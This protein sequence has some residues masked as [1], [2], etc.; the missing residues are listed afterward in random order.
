MT[1]ISD[2]LLSLKDDTYAAFTQKLAPNVPAERIL[3]VRMPALR[4]LARELKNSPEA[5]AFLKTLPH[6][7][8]DEDNLHALLINEIRDPS[9]AMTALDAFLP[10]V[11]NWATCDTLN[12]VCFKHNHAEMY[13]KIVEYVRSEHTYTMRF[14]VCAL[15]RHYLADDFDPS[16]PELLAGIISD[17]YYVNMAIAWYFATAVAQQPAAAIPYLASTRLPDWTRRKAI[18]KCKESYRVPASVKTQLTAS[19]PKKSKS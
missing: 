2:R 3:G 10:H 6:R 1:S 5:D 12:P 9:A 15:M 4:A 13:A 16:H 19:L 18:Q 7:Y 8:Y 14:G 11:N 17:E